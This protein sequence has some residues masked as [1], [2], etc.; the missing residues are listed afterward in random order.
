MSADYVADA[1]D[2]RIMGILHNDGRASN[3]AI[4]REL[5][6]SEAAIRKRLKRLT[7]LG[8]IRHGLLIDVTATNMRIFGW[9]YVEVHPALLS[10]A[11]KIIAGMDR[12]SGCAMKTG[13]YNLLAHVYAKDQRAMTQMIED[14]YRIEGV[15]RVHFRQ[16]NRYPL[17][18]HEYIVDTSENEFRS[19]HGNVAHAET[20]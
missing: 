18:R 8:L 19:W 17:H 16:V 3:R 13:D 6:L 1:V 5:E 11:Y 9:V 15:A 4:G 7:D 2:Q 20:S 10:A 12:C 14:L